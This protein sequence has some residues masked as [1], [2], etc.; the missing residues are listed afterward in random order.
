MV[1]VFQF[2][3]CKQQPYGTCLLAWN[4]LPASLH[5]ITDTSK[6]KK[7]LKTILFQ[8]AFPAALTVLLFRS[9]CS[10]VFIV[11]FLCFTVCYIVQR[12]WAAL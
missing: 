12:P 3:L 5:D 9:Y 6:F 4:A 7:S 8:R 2:I 1:V 10:T 11:L